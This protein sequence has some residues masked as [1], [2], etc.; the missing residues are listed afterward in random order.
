MSYTARDLDA[1][2]SI[3]NDAAVAM[4]DDDAYFALLLKMDPDQSIEHALGDRQEAAEAVRRAGLTD[5]QRAAEDA[6]MERGVQR[7]LAIMR[8]IM[9]RHKSDVK[10]ISPESSALVITADREA[11]VWPFRGSPFIPLGARSYRR[12]VEVDPIPAYPHNTDMV[13]ACLK[14]VA[15]LWPVGWPV[16]LYVLPCEDTG[17]TNGS[18]FVDYDYSHGEP[19]HHP[20]EAKISL[21]AKRIMP[22]PGMTRYLVAHEYGHVIEDFINTAVRGHDLG[23]RDTEREYAEL[24]GLSIQDDDQGGGRWHSSPCEVMANDFRVLVAGV[25]P[26]YWP[27][28]E[29]AYPYVANVIGHGSLRLWWSEQLK[30]CRELLEKS[31]S[32]P[33]VA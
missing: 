17:R 9:E 25:E 14:S 15:A 22:H 20:V 21:S 32:E 3:F 23:S 11:I 19:N 27:H 8:E 5:E 26:E 24:R 29:I 2:E 1:F 4:D 12:S 6:A 28:P 33:V 16:T 13:V 31:Q 30:A 10:F 7:G 18:T